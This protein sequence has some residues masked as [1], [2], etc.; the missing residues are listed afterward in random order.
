MPDSILQTV[1]SLLRYNGAAQSGVLEYLVRLPN[2]Q[3]SLPMIHVLLHSTNM[4]KVVDND[5]Y[6][7]EED[8]YYVDEEEHDE[9]CISWKCKFERWSICILKV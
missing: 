3:G 9:E 6:Y 1:C 8:E 4:L 7:D 5:E 2:S